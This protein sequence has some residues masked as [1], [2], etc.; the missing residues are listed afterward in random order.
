MFVDIND[1]PIMQL[2]IEEFIVGNNILKDEEEYFYFTKSYDVFFTGKIDYLY[3]EDIHKNI[4]LSKVNCKEIIFTNQYKDSM[5]NI[6]LPDNLQKLKIVRSNITKLPKLPRG[7]VKLNASCNNLTEVEDLPNFLEH[8]NL[9]TNNINFISNLPDGLI[10]LDLA[11]NNLQTIPVLPFGLERLYLSNNKI[12]YIDS[13]YDHTN[14]DI[15]SLTNNEITSIDKLPH[16]L[17][18]L[19]LCHNKINSICELPPYIKDFRCV[20]NQLKELPELPMTLM[21]IDLDCNPIEHIP[22]INGDIVFNFRGN[23]KSIYPST[24]FRF[25]KD[26]NLNIEIDDYGHIRNNKQF[27]RY[28]DYLLEKLYNDKV[29]MEPKLP[30]LINKVVGDIPPIKNNIIEDENIQLDINNCSFGKSFVNTLNLSCDSLKL[31]TDCCPNNSDDDED[32]IEYIPKP[33]NSNQTYTIGLDENGEFGFIPYK[34]TK[35]NQSNE[36]EENDCYQDDEGN[37]WKK[38]F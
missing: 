16:S 7:L 31:S 11:N 3:I 25:D 9:S 35:L 37:K 13:I 23:V 28:K 32:N 20:D 27:N 38:L 6:K 24:N 1:K 8:L 18:T 34:N 29:K 36:I 22:K 4:N 19:Y 15:L 2:D 5:E 26:S 30:T 33:L 12:K 10:T 17:S 21:N 14:L